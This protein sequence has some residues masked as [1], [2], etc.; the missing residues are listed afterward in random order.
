MFS[1]HVLLAIKSDTSLLCFTLYSPFASWLTQ[2]T[3]L[4]YSIYFQ[5]ILRVQSHTRSET[6]TL[7]GCCD[8]WIYVRRCLAQ[9]LGFVR[10]ND[11]SDYIETNYHTF[12]DFFFLR[13]YKAERQCNGCF[14]R[15]RCAGWV[16]KVEIVCPLSQKKD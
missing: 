4:D 12:V 3:R 11:I 8:L 9:Q 14:V 15:A 6:K 1:C 5:M 10:G 16:F 2:C 7:S 13:R